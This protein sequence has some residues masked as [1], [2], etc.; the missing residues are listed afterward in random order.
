MAAS[1]DVTTIKKQAQAQLVLLRERPEMLISLLAVILLV[2]GVFS[3]V[4]LSGVEQDIRQ[5]AAA[6]IYKGALC[7]QS[8]AKQTY[9]S[10]K[11]GELLLC[12]GKI[13][14]GTGKSC[15]ETITEKNTITDDFI[16]GKPTVNAG[17]NVCAQETCTIWIPE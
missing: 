10:D 12:N 8:Q 5:Q 13:W 15:G 17:G 7:E 1:F 4:L 6:A 14:E 2:V 3:A 9:C 16:D 11:T